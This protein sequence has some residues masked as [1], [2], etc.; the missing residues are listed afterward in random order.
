MKIHHDKTQEQ[1]SSILPGVQNEPT[2]GGTA[3]IADN[4][5][6][7]VY[8]R[9]LQETMNASVA[10]KTS[11]GWRKENKTGLPGH[12]KMGI[13]NLSGYSMDDVK[14]HYNS[15]KPAQLQAHAYAQGTDIHLG[16][17]QEKHLPH[18]AWHVVQQK[19]GRVQPTIQYQGKIAVNDDAGL[20][21]E[22]D[23]MGHNALG[24]GVTTS[25]AEGHGSKP[26]PLPRGPVFP[27]PVGPTVQLTKEEIDQYDM[28][29]GLSFKDLIDYQRDF[30]LKVI[31]DPEPFKEELTT[32][33]FEHEFAQSDGQ[34]L[35]GIS[36][37]TLTRS[38]SP[39]MAVTGLPFVLETD[40]NSAL[41]LVSPPFLLQ[42]EKGRPFPKQKLVDKVDEI[43]SSRLKKLAQEASDL[44]D[45]VARFRGLGIRFEP[46]SVPVFHATHISP[47][48]DPA[49]I[50]DF[51]HNRVSK[52]TIEQIPVLE[53]KKNDGRKFSQVNVA[54]DIESAF[55]MDPALNHIDT[56]HYETM[57]KHLVSKAILA[58]DDRVVDKNMVYFLHSLAKVLLSQLA[59]W[60]LRKLREHQDEQFK[61]PRKRGDKTIEKWW[62]FAI[63]TSFIK[64]V[65]GIWIKDSIINIG[66]GV[67][68]VEQWREINR[69]FN[70]QAFVYQVADVTIE[71]TDGLMH[72]AAKYFHVKKGGIRGF[73]NRFRIELANAL[74]T[75]IQSIKEVC[76]HLDADEEP[77]PVQLPPDVER[78]GHN[79]ASHIR[80][81][82]DTLIDPRGVNNH[83]MRILW[84][85]RFLHVAEVRG[86]APSN[87]FAQTSKKLNDISEKREGAP[88]FL[89]ARNTRQ[90]LG[91]VD[92]N[93]LAFDQLEVQ[94]NLGI[95]EI[96]FRQPHGVVPTD[97]DWLGDF[98][99]KTNLLDVVREYLR[100]NTPRTVLIQLNEGLD[101]D[102]PV[103]YKPRQSYNWLISEEI[104]HSILLNEKV[105]N[106]SDLHKSLLMAINALK[107]YEAEGE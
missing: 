94:Y 92:L 21:K 56:L 27:Q 63:Q 19:Q 35:K 75:L 5:L 2:T 65:T 80:A 82:Q 52:E 69:I 45:L 54:T 50:N 40:A 104:V 33:G 60:P 103:V 107:K 98:P 67:L 32:V 12:L 88:D 68:S 44:S 93:T 61:N 89:N 96:L 46:L 48:T 55:F 22:A 10:S 18:E 58:L 76:G 29:K 9:K 97:W 62:Q 24:L 53:S 99:Y 31:N 34:W 8:Q 77:L 66:L 102:L 84:P 1:Q 11:T 26:G 41:E 47:A 74:K 83:L 71:G 91:K 4:R 15:S 79:P 13:E 38:T 90:N 100:Q 14:V 78:Y 30:Q 81:R 28:I 59:V 105:K 101:V 37:L 43:M 42:T 72:M 57:Q 39:I 7:T 51:K 25:K 86:N 3:T 85:G 49:M 95:V 20:E 23:V 64:D 73:V 36:H 17:G 16:P 70:N 106:G 6:S 87:I